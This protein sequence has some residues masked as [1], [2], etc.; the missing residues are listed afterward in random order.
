VAVER[1]AGHKAVVWAELSGWEQHFCA[2]N[3]AFCANLGP[4]GRRH[5]VDSFGYTAIYEMYLQG[6][7]YSRT[8]YSK[9]HIFAEY[10]S[11]N[12]LL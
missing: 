3:V 7:C 11:L 8:F 9:I 2:R 1:S 4:N 5:L 12:A 10:L 6:E